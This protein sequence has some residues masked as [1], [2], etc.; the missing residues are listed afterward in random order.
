LIGRKGDVAV[1]YWILGDVGSDGLLSS[2][3]KIISGE[4]SVSLD[5]LSDESIRS[6]VESFDA[7]CVSDIGTGP[8][9]SDFFVQ[10]RYSRIIFRCKVDYTNNGFSVQVAPPIVDILERQRQKIEIQK[11]EELNKDTFYY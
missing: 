5:S 1:Q 11:F 4:F 9:S 8:D 3:S 10:H 2:G 6:R 7:V